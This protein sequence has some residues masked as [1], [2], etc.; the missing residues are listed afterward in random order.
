M[1]TNTTPKSYNELVDLVRHNLKQAS[2]DATDPAEKGKV[3]PKTT[4]G[5]DASKMALPGKGQPLS[6]AT[7][8]LTDRTTNPA[9][10][11]ENREPMPASGDAKD[12][13]VSSPTD[14][15]S[16]IAG[17]AEDIVTRL[18]GLLKSSSEEAAAPAAD[19]AAPAADPAAEPK[20]AATGAAE[21][22]VE[23]TPE[24]HMK[25]AATIL[26]SQEGVDLAS[27]LLRKQAGVEAAQELMGNALAMHEKFASIATQQADEQAQETE[28]DNLIKSASPQDQEQ[29]VKFAK[30]H[31]YCMRQIQDPIEK[32]AFAQ[33]AMDAAAMDE[34][35]AATGQPG[36][37]GAEGEPSPE[38]I[39]QV[40]QQMVAA[41]EIDEATAQQVV[42]LL[43]QGMGGGEEAAGDPAAAEAAA[44]EEVPE[45]VK[46]A[47]ALLYGTK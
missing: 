39:L 24:F 35:A 26:S 14:P 5:D 32:V 37:P 25:L 3:S 34:T 15:L 28:L 21:T 2:I 8:Q 13:S 45:E 27:S 16:K 12:K 7:E 31:D 43:A 38:E 22:T 20:A 4:D 29:I 18:R 19:P 11:G 40:L 41:G 23:L 17:K 1:A 36:L 10:V 9:G 47:A 42:E 44:E 30:T 6:P 33:G 46:A